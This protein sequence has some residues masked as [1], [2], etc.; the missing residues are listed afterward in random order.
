[1][2]VLLAQVL[3]AALDETNGWLATQGHPFR[4]ILVNATNARQ[5]AL[6]IEQSGDGRRKVGW[7]W[8]T[9]Y[10][11][12]VRHR[13]AWMYAMVRGR[14]SAARA[15]ALCYGRVELR[16]GHVSLEYLERARHARD[17]KGLTVFTAF[18]FARTVAL[19]LGI[20]EVRVNDPFPQLVAYY[21]RALNANRHPTEGPVQYLYT[22]IKP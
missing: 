6:D 22:R 13:K 11:R 19:L 15:R 18:Q 3:A 5:M 14:R 12:R 17:I 8:E 21:E 10:F 16:H 2:P 1:M 7:D 4:L 20:G 9:L